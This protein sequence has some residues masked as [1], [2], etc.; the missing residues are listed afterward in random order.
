MRRA[1]LSWPCSVHPACTIYHV[2]PRRASATIHVRTLSAM[3]RRWE[4]DGPGGATAATAISPPPQP[5]GDWRRGLKAAV[6]KI[7]HRGRKR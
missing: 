5:V 2:S 3:Q 4:G 1:P 7:W 6:I